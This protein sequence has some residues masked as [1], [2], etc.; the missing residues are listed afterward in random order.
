MSSLLCPLDSNAPSTFHALINEVLKPFLRK[1]VLVFFDDIL[2]NSPSMELQGLKNIWGTLSQQREL[3]DPKKLNLGGYGL[4]QRILKGYMD[5]WEAQH[6]FD[7]I[8]NIITTLL[9]EIG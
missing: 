9:I 1:F 6:A 2:V 4:Y 5:S 8:K 3:F 7:Q